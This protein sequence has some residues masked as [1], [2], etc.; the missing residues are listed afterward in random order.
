MFYPHQKNTRKQVDKAE[1]VR[2]YG[3]IKLEIYVNTTKNKFIK[4]K[5]R[6]SCSRSQLITTNVKAMKNA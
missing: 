1:F 4:I 2:L 6:L 5:R 3:V